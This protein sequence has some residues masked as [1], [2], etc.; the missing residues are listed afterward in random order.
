VTSEPAS[1]VPQLASGRTQRSAAS[2]RLSGGIWKIATSPSVA[3][4]PASV[5]FAASC[6]PA[7]CVAAGFSQAND[8]SVGTLIERD[9]DIGELP[10]ADILIGHQKLY[11]GQRRSTAIAVTP[12]ARPPAGEG[13]DCAAG[14]PPVSWEASLI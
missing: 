11:L 10:E 3:R 14:H 13:W 4:L 7:H 2:E 1:A 8:G 9:C 6:R 12:S 5:L